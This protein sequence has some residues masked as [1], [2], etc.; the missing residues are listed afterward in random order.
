MRRLLWILLSCLALARPAAAELRP[1]RVEGNRL[2]DDRG[3]SV[4]LRG[5]NFGNWFVLETYFYGTDF[6]D[7]RSVWRTLLRRFGP[8]GLERVKEAHFSN[9]ITAE[10]FARVKAL[11]L[12]SVRVPF[13]D[14]MFEDP[15]HPGQLSADGW[16]WLDFA[17]DSCESA[18]V[19]CVLDLHGAPGGQSVADHTGEQNR[20]A[21]WGS[22][23]NRRAAAQLWAAVAARYRGRAAIA[24]FDL[25]NEPM[26]APTNQEMAAAQGELLAAVRSADP[27]RVAVIED[28]YRG[29]DVLPSPAQ[30]GWTNVMYSQH[31]YPAMGTDGPPPPSQYDAYFQDF[32]DST[33][34]GVALQAHR[35]QG[36][37]YVGEWNII[38]GGPGGAEGG[39]MTR[40]YID[41]MERLGW[42]W[43]V[44][45]YKQAKAKGVTSDELWSFYRN[46][47][48]TG[49]P[50]FERDSLDDI[51]RKIQGLRTENMALS[52]AMGGA[53][54][55][56]PPPPP[57]PAV[58]PAARLNLPSK[59]T[60]AVPAF[61]RM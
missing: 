43:A 19:Y 46:D 1:L 40:H 24:A 12:N 30:S 52:S 49:V 11:G 15:A 51:V 36:P 32:I 55:Q 14:G 31:M 8:A 6:P 54:R 20:N 57:A 3:D 48:K 50:D 23:D 47:R 61:G 27:E 59:L 16:R 9:W 41:A 35:L 21:Y 34:P 60:L 4:I 26:G 5:V 44:W 13:W 28:A 58:S 53:V 22:A 2:V 42:S 56:A 10:D 38:H 39:R 33:F 25:L 29:L 45:T 17:V 18:G 37:V 7:E